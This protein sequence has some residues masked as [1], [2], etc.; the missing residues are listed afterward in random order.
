MILNCRPSVNLRQLPVWNGRN[1][2]I[3]QFPKTHLF[4]RISVTICLQHGIQHSFLRVPFAPDKCTNF[5]L[6][7]HDVVRYFTF[8][9]GARYCSWRAFTIQSLP[10]TDL[11]P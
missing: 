9:V 10:K 11:F 1:C 3:V 8:D 6:H 2:A 5:V 4:Q 7:V